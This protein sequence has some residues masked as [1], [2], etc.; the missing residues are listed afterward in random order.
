MPS[1]SA[2]RLRSSLAVAFLTLASPTLAACTVAVFVTAS[3]TAAFSQRS[4]GS[5]GSRNI[6][7]LSH[8]PLGRIFTVSDVVI[9]QELA[10]P[11]AYVSRMIGRLAPEAG[12]DIVSVKAPAK[13]SVLYRWRIEYPELHQGGGGMAPAYFKTRGRYYF[14]QSLQFNP[15]GP[16]ADVG[17]VAFDVTGLPDTGA[18]REIGR[19]R[20]ADGPG[21]F[22]EIFPYKHSSGRALLFAVTQSPFGHVYDLDRFVSGDTARALA[23]RL[24][25]PDTSFGGSLRAY[26]D[27]YAAYDPVSRQDRFYGAGSSGYYVYDVTDLANPKLLTS[28][29]G[30]AGVRS[31][32][33]FVATPD[34]RYGVTEAE[35]Q[36]APLRI[37]DLKPGLDGQVSTISRPIGAWIS[38]WRTNPHNLQIRWPYVFVAAYEE[39]LQVFNLMDPTNPHT[40]AYYDTYEG[41]HARG[42]APVV[43]NPEAR[44]EDPAFP[45]P[46]AYAVVNGAWGIDVRNADGLIVVSDLASG[47]WTFRMDGFDGWNGHQWG[48]PNISS[49]Q[50]WDHGPD[51]APR[52]TS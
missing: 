51:G 44:W 11:Y 31:G 34:G 17:A 27:M 21:G 43:G 10:R 23:L 33:T 28:I 29:I 13:A 9:E 37:F 47:F 22:H 25:I 16:D 49:A 35:Y 45:I 14:V 7:V 41:P 4:P 19:L 15:S 52:K 8:L 32:H 1:I 40:V 36:Y 26:H 5:Q 30:V 20:V 3:P 38:D 18:V 42:R 24:P 12:F 2:D 46:S 48:M 39:G 50:D 6:R